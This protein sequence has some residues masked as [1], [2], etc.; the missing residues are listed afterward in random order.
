M[1]KT[2]RPIAGQKCQVP[3]V[4]EEDPPVNEARTDS[5]D[6]LA[7]EV[8]DLERYEQ[9]NSPRHVTYF[10]IWGSRSIKTFHHCLQF[11]FRIKH[12]LKLINSSNCRA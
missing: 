10:W 7:S 6:I 4:N 11:I 8:R 3:N 1:I 12:F 5:E 9:F 2:L